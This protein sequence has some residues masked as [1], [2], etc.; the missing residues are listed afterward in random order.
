MTQP[1]RTAV[2]ALVLVAAVVEGRRTIGLAAALAGPQEPPSTFR[3]GVDLIQLDVSVLD[4]QRHPVNGLTASDFTVRVDG[5]VRPL[6][7]FKA[8]TLPPPLPPPSAPWIRDVAPDVITNTHPGGRAIVIMVDD[9]SVPPIESK[10]NKAIFWMLKARVTAR[11]VV[12]ELGPDDVAAVVFTSN[13]HTA[14]GFTS[15]RERLLTAIEKSV[16]LPAPLML[17]DTGVPYAKPSNP[18]EQN[19][20]CYCRICSVE[21][22]AYIAD[23]LRSL[24]QERKII[25]YLSSG[26]GIRPDINDPCNMM[27]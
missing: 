2:L 25:I 12:D 26:V 14:Q 20:Y 15:D 13:N 18:R 27:R 17:G 7:A 4:K 6:V 3:S 16:L 19:G 23:S 24:P 8:V 5:V 11:R 22:L 21:A 9:A 1:S 10:D